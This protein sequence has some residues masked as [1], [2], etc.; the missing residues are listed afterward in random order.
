MDFEIITAFPDLIQ[1]VTPYGV[2]GRALSRSVYRIRCWNPR[3]FTTDPYRRIDDRPYG[4]GPGMVMLAEPLARCASALRQARAAEGRPPLRLIHLSPQG[5][6]LTQARVREWA[7]GDGLALLCGRYEAIDQRFLDAEVDE[8]VSIGDFIVSGGELP[9]LLLID[10]IVRLMPGVLNDAASAQ[11]DSFTG[12]LLDCPHYTR[13]EHLGDTDAGRVPA[14]LLSGNHRDIERWRRDA[15]LLATAR[16]RPDLLARARA[17]GALDR[18][19]LK[20]L[21]R[22]DEPHAKTTTPEDLSAGG[23]T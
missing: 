10:A 8:E 21:D 12:D 5:V 6:P 3:D 9:A 18:E 2:T 16:K 7:V 11:Q 23:G 4:G 19:D 14:V 1:S 22:L 15:S 20:R 13:P 17:A